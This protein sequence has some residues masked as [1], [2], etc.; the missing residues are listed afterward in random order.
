M[1][2]DDII[3]DDHHPNTRV[4]AIAIDESEASWE[5]L[6]WA[7]INVLRETD[8]VVLLHS[9]PNSEVGPFGAAYTDADFSHELTEQF[10]HSYKAQSHSVL[11]KGIEFLK[12]KKFY[13]QAI[14]LKGDAREELTR[15]VEELK[16]KLLVIGSRGMGMLK[17]TLIGST[18][19][20]LTHHVHC[21]VLVH[22][23]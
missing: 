8:L 16:V 15:K 3:H 20:Y 12:S 6:K 7:A 1:T 17:R 22:K 18:S 9:R 13:V 21:P 19:D 23:H 14:S 10:E 4:V 11:K 2:A 5:A